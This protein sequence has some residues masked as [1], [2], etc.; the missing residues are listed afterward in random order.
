MRYELKKRLRYIDAMRGLAILLVVF[1][2]VT[3]A[4][5]R[6]PITN[7]SFAG[8]YYMMTMFR[9]PL[10][11]FV[12]GFFAFRM[13]EKWTWP[14]VRRVMT[15]KFQAQIVGLAVF[16]FLYGA[17][18][19]G[20]KFHF[21]WTSNP[22][23]FT[24]SLFEMFVIYLSIA[25]IVRKTG[26]DIPLY[27][28][29]VLSFIA[30]FVFNYLTDGLKL[31]RWVVGLQTWHTLNYWPYF[32][33]GIF[34][35]R[36]EAFTWKMI[37][38]QYF[39]AVMIVGFFALVLFYGCRHR[40]SLEW[41]FV[42]TAMRFTGLMTI[43]ISFRSY[44]DWFDRGTALSNCMSFVGSRTL[45]I[46]YLHYFFIPDLSFMK[47]F[48]SSGPGNHILVMLL[49]GLTVSALVIA[50][51]LTVSAVLRSSPFLSS[52]LFGANSHNPLVYKP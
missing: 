23:W 11:F 19:R 21:L 45:D 20:W 43:L 41:D 26:S 16:S 13:A 17:C 25:L 4:Y 9:M 27:L 52:W 29:L 38:N 44:R 28:L 2:H 37:D 14:T 8:V 3:N 35:R 36:F 18:M 33:M 1:S 7:S 34:A 49:I 31:P 24:I 39:K 32:M 12:S 22:Y 5:V 42:M 48:L 50:L 51:C 30:P 46:Y 15:K 6:M 47:G 40:Y 10:F